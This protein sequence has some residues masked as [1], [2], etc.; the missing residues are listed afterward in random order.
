MKMTRFSIRQAT[1]AATASLAF[2]LASPI[3]TPVLAADLGVAPIYR[4]FAPV[5]N[6]TGSYIGISGGGTWGS[7]D[8]HNDFTG[9]QTPSFDLH[10]GLVGITTGYNLQSRN[11]VYGYESDTSITGKQGSA[12]DFPPN[13]AFSSQVK[14]PW[15]STYRGRVG[16]AANNWM[17]YA[18]GG[19]ALAEV[20]NN[21]AGPPGTISEQHWHWGWTVGGGVEMKLTP[22]WSAKVE[23]L[24][25][26]LQDKS[27][28]NPAPSA[29]FPGNQ[30][31]SLDDHIVRVGVNYKLPWGILDSFFKPGR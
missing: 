17:I 3:R 31:V 14:E 18:T 20:Q 8:V 7:S 2:V 24:Y 27:Y 6:W 30:H 10:G 4:P 13:G 23:Y 25:V 1:C 11:I 22:D 16:Y 12:L 21:L 15:L 26:G 5:A 28:F 29:V 9:D 19:G